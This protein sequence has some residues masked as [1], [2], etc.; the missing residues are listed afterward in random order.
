MGAEKHNLKGN[1]TWK[2][3]AG[4]SICVIDRGLVRFDYPSDWIV[5]PEEGA[6]H[7]HDRPPSVESC[8]LGVSIFRVPAAHVWQL[9]LD[10]TLRDTLADDRQPYQ[11]SE[12]QH[13]AHGDVDIAWLEQRHIDADYQRDGRFRVA[14]ARGAVICLITMN[15]WS[16]GAA[17][18][19]GVWDEVLRTL[20][21]GMRIEDPT[22]GPVIQ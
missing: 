1:H 8:D 13:I 6:V 2:S 11:Q 19:E 3:K 16:D 14:L 21:I 4:Y 10:D 22:A 15:Y 20:V 7:L 9:S 18:L 5:E 17:G 12:I